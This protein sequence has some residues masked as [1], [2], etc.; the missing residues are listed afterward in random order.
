MS[1]YERISDLSVTIES[2]ERRR[3]TERT[4]SGFERTTTE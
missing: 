2:V 4:T 3:Y 1:A